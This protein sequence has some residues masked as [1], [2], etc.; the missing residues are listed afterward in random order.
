MKPNCE[1]ENYFLNF[2]QKANECLFLEDTIKLSQHI[3]YDC[4]LVNENW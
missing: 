3:P 2:F 4:L 1:L